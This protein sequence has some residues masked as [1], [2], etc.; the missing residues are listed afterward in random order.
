MISVFLLAVA[1]VVPSAGEED[2]IAFDDNYRSTST[3]SDKTF[4][5][6]IKKKR[7]YVSEETVISGVSGTI[8]GYFH[9]VGTWKFDPKSRQ[10]IAN[11][12]GVESITSSRGN[13]RYTS[14]KEFKFRQP[15][16]GMYLVTSG[17]DRLIYDSDIDPD[18]FVRD[19]KKA[20]EAK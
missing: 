6:D 17:K 4:L 19:V 7:F 10:F 11:V 3:T 1:M 20:A 18:E 16:G 14:K 9:G 15:D 13:H 2:M 12:T 8:V 5:F